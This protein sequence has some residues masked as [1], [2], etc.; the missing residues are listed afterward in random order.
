MADEDRLILDSL[1]GK[2][3]LL[4][5]D[6]TDPETTQVVRIEHAGRDL[7]VIMPLFYEGIGIGEVVAAA[8][9]RETVF[10]LCRH[11]R[12]LD[13]HYGI[14]GLL[15]VAVPYREGRYRAVIAHAT[16]ALEESTDE[17]EGLGLYAVTPAQAPVEDREGGRAELRR[18]RDRIDELESYVH[19]LEHDL[20][21]QIFRLENKLIDKIHQLENK[22]ID[23]IH[24]LEID[25]IRS[26]TRP[27]S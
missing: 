17:R 1:T 2:H 5:I 15:V 10:V 13:D 3:E 19:R 11:D 21:N 4:S 24:R 27:P 16:H 18:L 26:S 23:K 9:D 20:G 12:P 22:F 6:P 14:L 7:E 8:V 25:L